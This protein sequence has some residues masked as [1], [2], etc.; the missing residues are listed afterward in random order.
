MSVAGARE[1]AVATCNERCFMVPWRQVRIQAC[2]RRGWDKTARGNAMHKARLISGR[3]WPHPRI[4]I[5]GLIMVF[6]DYTVRLAFARLAPGLLGALDF[7]D[8]PSWGRQAKE[9]GS[10]LTFLLYSFD[11]FFI[12]SPVSGGFP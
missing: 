7:T 5:Y 10:S 11:L 12:L 2:A 6:F 1:K 3:H 9:E 8:P 4:G